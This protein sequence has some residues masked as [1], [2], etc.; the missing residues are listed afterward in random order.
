[1]ETFILLSCAGGYGGAEKSLELLAAELANRGLVIVLAENKNHIDALSQIKGNIVVK[2][3]PKGKS[4]L[5]IFKSLFTI[6]KYFSK[7]TNAKILVNTNK[8]ALYLALL[9]YLISL[10]KKRII[11]YVRDYQWKYTDFIFSK[12]K[13]VEYAIP[14]ESILERDQYLNSYI[15]RD[16]VHITGNPVLLP[17]EELTQQQGSYFLLLANISRWK[18]IDY[19]LKAYFTSGLYKENINVKVCGKVVDNAYFEQLQ[20]Y[21]SVNKLSQYVEF[22]PFQKNTRTLYENSLAVVNCS[23]SEFGGPETF[24]RTII[25]AWSYKKPVISFKCGG[26][27]YIVTDEKNG[28]LVPEKSVE[29]LSESML[30]IAHN[31]GIAIQMGQNGFSNIGKNYTP[32]II[33]EHL[34]DIWNS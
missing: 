9:S 16:H 2:Q 28:F 7:Y 24:G 19:L 5:I 22:I 25:E 11:I 13:N 31:P 12:L 34:F 26:P 27:K 17:H 1:M 33:V 32:D 10:T 8:G 20:Q 15:P 23:I 29:K 30:R 3:L 14:T 4:P 6:R 18:G 21:L